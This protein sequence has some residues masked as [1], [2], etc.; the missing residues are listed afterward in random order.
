MELR[1]R[2]PLTYKIVFVLGFSVLALLVPYYSL[3]IIFGTVAII[4]LGLA[5]RR[6]G[7]LFIVLAIVF[8]V[9][10]SSIV[11]I[12]RSNFFFSPF[13]FMQ[14]V[15]PY[16]G[17]R[18]GFLTSGRNQKVYPD[19]FIKSA[20]N[21][22]LNVEGLNLVFDSESTRIEIPSELSVRR[23]D[24]KVEISSVQNGFS[25][26]DYVVN[27]G[28]KN[29]YDNVH[30]ESSGLII[31]GKTAQKIGFL[32]VN[33]DGISISGILKADNLRITCDGVDLGG[34]IDAKN[35]E[36]NANGVFVHLSLKNAQKFSLNCDGITGSVTYEDTWNGVRLFSVKSDAGHLSVKIP[37]S[38]GDLNMQTRGVL[39]DVVRY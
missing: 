37:Q 39:V 12:V 3:K 9:L 16:Y 22:Y 21:V 5:F 19:K 35:I 6:F 27:V 8:V 13:Y 1:R 11:G 28:T 7:T 14:K 25:N 33:C 32:N 17:H 38:A 4:I 23:F 30:V 10:P 29:G 2:Y 26:K 20:Q 31:G 24:K 36:I 15:I 18:Y 34:E